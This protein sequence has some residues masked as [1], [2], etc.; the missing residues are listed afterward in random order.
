MCCIFMFHRRPANISLNI[1]GFWL[2]K[3]SETD[4]FHKK[5]SLLGFKTVLVPNIQC[6]MFHFRENMN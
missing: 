1:F 2:Q 6:D 5:K 3:G 4:Q